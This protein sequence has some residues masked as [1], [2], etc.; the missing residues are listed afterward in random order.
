MLTIRR[1]LSCVIFFIL[2][3]ASSAQI[4][5]Q[6]LTTQWE[7]D[8]TVDA[9]KAKKNPGVA[10]AAEN[11]LGLMG[12]SLSVATITDRLTFKNNGYAITSQAQANRL[13][14]SLLPNST[15]TRTSRG[16][17]DGGYLVS[18]EFTEERTKGHLRKVQ[19]DYAK[20]TSDYFKSGQLV[21]REALPYRTADTATLPYLFYKKPPPA[22]RTFVAAT[23]GISTRI[24]RFAPSPDS[25]AIDGKNIPAIK[26]THQ[27]LSQ[28]EAGLTLWI[29]KSDGF[30][31]R[32]RL[33]MNA[34]YGA[35]MD[36]KLKELPAGV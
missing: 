14:S 23:D 20:K 16:R 9:N 18:V 11:I 4:Q 27:A 36:Q 32:V 26:L 7:V 8:V 33:D 28:N 5:N 35:I 10:K 19:L 6:T 15:A 2:S 25:V 29:R 12:G 13:I 31:L 3:A 30:P 34:R 22:G 1:S 21:K 17:S 24:F